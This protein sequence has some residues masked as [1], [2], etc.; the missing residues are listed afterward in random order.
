MFRRF[1]ETTLVD[2]KMLNQ[3]TFFSF[4]EISD[5]FESPSGCFLI[6]GDGNSNLFYNVTYIYFFNYQ[7]FP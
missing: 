1:T 3:N 7:I 6:Y 5:E 4:A 2:I